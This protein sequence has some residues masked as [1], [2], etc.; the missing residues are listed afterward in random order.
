MIF[1]FDNL[2]ATLIGMAVFVLIAAIQL[3]TTQANIAETSRNIV[4]EQAQDFATWVEDELETMGT[5][6]DPGAAPP[7]EVPFENPIDSAGVTTEFTFYRDSVVNPS[8]TIRI[9]TRY[10][11]HRTGTRVVGKD[12]MDLYE[13]ER[14]QKVG[15]GSWAS[16]GRSAAALGY[17]DIDMLNRDAQPITNP[18]SVASSNPDSV[19]STRVRFS[20]VAPFQSK[21]TSLRV[22][23]FGSVLLV[24]NEE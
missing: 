22:V 3:R 24:R 6:M 16:D 7:Y 2:T 12:T 4:K 14:W 13:M 9:Q 23:H 5:N 17:F 19:R 21:R 1:I 8:N 10:E 18:K 11:L 15:S 20:M